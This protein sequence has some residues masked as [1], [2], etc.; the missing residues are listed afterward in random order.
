MEHPLESVYSG[1]AGEYSRMMSR[2]LESPRSFLYFSFLV[3]LG[4]LLCDKITL[5]SQVS[6]ETRLFLLLLGESAWDRKSTAIVQTVK[7][8]LEAISDFPVCWGVGSAEGLAEQFK[9]TNR[10]LLVQDEF[11]QFVSKAKI[12]GSVLLEVT[13]TLFEQNRYESRTKKHAI[14]ITDAQL[15]ILAAS[16]VETYQ[17]MFDARFWDMGFLNRILIIKDHGY[18][19]W[20]IPPKVDDGEKA[21]L[22]KRLGELLQVYREAAGEGTAEIPLDVEAFERFDLWYTDELPQTIHSKRLDT[23]GH[24]LMLLLAVNDLKTRVDTETVEKVITILNWVYYNRCQ[25]DPIQADN[26]VA[27][28]EESIRRST[29]QGISLR[30]LKRA[31]NYNRYGLYIFNTALNNLLKAKEIAYD[32]KTR[33][34]YP[35]AEETF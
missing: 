17:T 6:P 18:R 23:Y 21:A 3:C 14:D 19:R 28:M 11:R 12:E 34:Y 33:L 32:A 25:T 20:A 8:F 31:V 35:M 26:K 29:D 1:L 30:E 15:S 22:K 7:F 5:A 10:V 4:I 27:R 13:N 16:T 2:V 24:R 9:K